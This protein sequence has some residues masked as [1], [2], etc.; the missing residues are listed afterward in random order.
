M[1]KRKL[2]LIFTGVAMCGTVV[3]N[4]VTGMRTLKYKQ[5]LDEC[6]GN[7][8][9]AFMKT[10]WPSMVLG[11]ATMTSMAL[12]EKANLAEIG[13]LTGACG[14][15]ASKAKGLENAVKECLDDERQAE[16]REETVRYVK[17]PGPSVEE[18]G[19][20]DV[21]CLEDYSGRWFRSSEEAVRRAAL[22]FKK[23]HDDG[24]YVCFNDLYTL[25]GI[26]ETKF[27]YDY[28][29]P[30][31]SD[32]CDEQ[33]IIDIDY[34]EGVTDRFGEPVLVLTIQSFPMENWQE[35]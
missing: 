5:I 1:D 14:Y 30:A 29:F 13:V 31:N 15:L 17:L 35:V 21:L 6:E 12:A 11:A 23:M 28:G 10:Y 32:Y 9:K 20:G 26:V 18:T 25:L 24:L 22:E 19:R 2:G 3:T 16:V 4:V 27:G 34:Y 7:K 8:P 33:L